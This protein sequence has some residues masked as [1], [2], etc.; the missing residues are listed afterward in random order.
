MATGCKTDG[1]WFD[2]YKVD[3]V[4]LLRET[5]QYNTQ[6]IQPTVQWVPGIK[7][8]GL[9]PTKKHRTSNMKEELFIPPLTVPF[10]K[11]EIYIYLLLTKDV[12]G[13]LLRGYIKERNLCVIH[14]LQIT[15][16]SAAS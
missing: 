6:P 8:L 3:D 5:C 9:K 7:F 4:F 1:P 13:M 11:G 15:M 2:C 14:D 16:H 12:S 10:V